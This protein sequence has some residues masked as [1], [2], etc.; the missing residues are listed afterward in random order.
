MRPLVNCEFCEFAFFFA[1]PHIVRGLEALSIME[2]LACASKGGGVRRDGDAI[3]RKRGSGAEPWG[4]APLP[5]GLPPCG[6]G[7][8]GLRP[9]GCG[10]AGVGARARIRGVV[11]RRP[12][13]Q[14]IM[15]AKVKFSKVVEVT[16]ATTRSASS[17]RK[18]EKSGARGDACPYL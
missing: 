5:A 10:V 13:G 11:R 6:R 4:C 9:V 18:R 3:F 15:A 1:A 17:V 16:P 2:G 12:Y 8:V 7:G 14:K